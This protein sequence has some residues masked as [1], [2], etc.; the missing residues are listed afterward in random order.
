[1]NARSVIRI[2]GGYFLPAAP[3]V[4]TIAEGFGGGLGADPIEEITKRTGLWCLIVLL[5]TL[6]ITPAR[7]LLNSSGIIGL[8]RPWGLWAFTYGVM[9]MLT[10]VWLDKFFEWKDVARDIVK[11]P[12]I[13][14]GTAA[15]LVMVPLAITSTDAMMRRL[16]RNWQKLHRLAYAAA[17]IG[18]VHFWWLVKKDV[19]EPAIFLAVFLLLMGLRLLPNR[20]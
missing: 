16:G 4:W 1:M 15:F 7:K 13:T 9:H 18:I 5:S 3:A 10:Y 6:A 20:S 8:R 17:A 2:A 11:R 12:F 19:T 14:A